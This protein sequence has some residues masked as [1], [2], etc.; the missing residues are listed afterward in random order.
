MCDIKSDSN[1]SAM[2]SD[3]NR[4]YNGILFDWICVSY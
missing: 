3:F 2:S 1:C 4:K